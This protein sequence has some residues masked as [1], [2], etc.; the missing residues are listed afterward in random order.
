MW[1]PSMKSTVDKKLLTQMSLLEKHQLSWKKIN[2]AYDDHVII[3]K[4]S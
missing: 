4:T 2:Q 3:A 1:G